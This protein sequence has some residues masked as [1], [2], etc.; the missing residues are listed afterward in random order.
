MAVMGD[1]R[2]HHAAAGRAA[3]EILLGFQLFFTLL[4]NLHAD[5]LGHLLSSP[6]L[7]RLYCAYA[8]LHM[9]MMVAMQLAHRMDGDNHGAPQFWTKIL[10]MRSLVKCDDGTVK[11][12][13]QWSISQGKKK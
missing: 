1:N 3:N 2:S 10:L 13:G 5:L 11:W 6:L 4:S 12:H 7:W 8:K 9:V